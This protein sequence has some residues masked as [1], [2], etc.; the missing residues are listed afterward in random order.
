MTYYQLKLKVDNILLVDNTDDN[1]LLFDNTLSVDNM[2]SVV[3]MLSGCCLTTCYQLI[4]RVIG[5][6]NLYSKH[7][8]STLNAWGILTHF[9]DNVKKD[10]IS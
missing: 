10:I 1:M 2:L 3:N 6:C 9:Q 7:R 5:Q 8:L 4:H